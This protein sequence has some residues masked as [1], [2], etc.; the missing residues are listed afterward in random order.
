MNLNNNRNN[1]THHAQAGASSDAPRN[2]RLVPLAHDDDAPHEMARL[3]AS[4][5]IELDTSQRDA[6]SGSAPEAAAWSLWELP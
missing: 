4:K 6:H 5:R 3:P 1:S 2:N